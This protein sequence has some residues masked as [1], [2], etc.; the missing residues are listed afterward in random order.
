[1][2][3]KQFVASIGYASYIVH[4]EDIAALLAI[5]RRSIKLE[6]YPAKIS[7]DQESFITTIS[8]CEVDISTKRSRAMK[9]PPH[10]WF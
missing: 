8:L 9:A 10:K 1:M 5:S 6:G 4:E 7:D 2:K 3:M